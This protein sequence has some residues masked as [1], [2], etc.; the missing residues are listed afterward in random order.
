MADS[1]NVGYASV[2]VIPVVKDIGNNTAT[3]LGVPMAKAGEAAGKAAGAGIVNGLSASKAA[4]EKASAGIAAARR[5]EEDAAGKVRTAE[6]QLQSLRSRGI[7]DVGRLTA[8]EEKVA[9]ARRDEAAASDKTKTATADLERAQ[10]KHADTLNGTA[11]ASKNAASGITQ[12]GD[13]SDATAGRVQAFSLGAVAGAGLALLADKAMEAVKFIGE[14]GETFEVVRS[15][16]QLSTGASGAAL[17]GLTESVKNVAK[18]SPASIGVISERMTQLYQR[19]GLTGESLETLTKQVNKA[20]A[21]LGQ[22]LDIR[23]I[24]QSMA[25]FG[26]QGKDMSGVLDD[27]F[28]VARS[29][30]VGMNELAGSVIRAAPSLQEFGFSLS[31]SVS[32]VGNLDKA[33]VDASSVLQTFGKGLVSIAKAG[34]S[35]KEAFKD[36]TTQIQG[37]IKA[38]DTAGAVNVAGK[39]FGTKGAV[40]FVNAVKSG[41]LNMEQLNGT[42]K[43]AGD[44][45][46]DA[47]GATVTFAKVWGLFKNN[48]IIALEPLATR[49]FEVFIE[50]LSWIKTNGT[51]ALTSLTAVL[52]PVFDAVAPLADRIFPALGTAISGVGTAVTAVTGWMNDHR[53]AM[54]VLGIVVATILTPYLITL[55]VQ[56]TIMGGKAVVA[57]AQNAAAWVMLR[58]E[59]AK[60]AV[61]TVASAWKTVG[62]WI[63]MGAQ[64]VAQGARASAAWVASGARSAGAWIALRLGATGSFL[65]TAASAVA[66]GVRTS[67]AW[68]ASGVKSAAGWAAMKA[69]AVGSFIA[70]AAGAVA[71]AGRTAAVWVASNARIAITTGIA[72]AAFIAQRAAQIA[73][74]IATGALTAA[75]WALNAAMSANPIGLIIAVVVAL[76]AAIVLA[77]KNSETFRNVIQAAWNGIKVVIAAVWG[78]LSTTVFPLFQAAIQ[79]VGSVVMWLWNNVMQPAWNGIRTVIGLWW[80]GVQVYFQFWRSAIS[81]AGDVVMW[82]WN[83]VISPA[84]NGIGSVISGIWSGVISPIF[85]G[86]K[87][88]IQAVGDIVNWLWNNVMI[89]AWD[90]IKNAISAVWNFIRPILD[91]IGKGIHAV[92]E[93]AS[94]VG[95][96][97]RNAFDGVVDVLKSPIH[98]VGKLLASLPGSVMGIDIPGVSTIK[99]WGE[100]LQALRTG[101]TV[102]NGMAGRTRNGVLWGPGSGTSDSILGVDANGIPTA[103]VSNQEGVVTAKAMANGG[104]ALVAW[105]NKTGGLPAFATGGQ[106]GEPYGLPTGSNISYGAPGFPDWVTK[107]GAEHNVKPSTYAG[108]QESDR[109]E[110]GYAPNPQHLNRG[111]DWNGSVE[112]MDAFARWLIGIAPDSPPLEQI[113]WQN[114]NTG[115]KVGWHGRSP[116]AGFSYFAADYGGH[117]DHVHTRQ[118]AAFG[119]SKPP[120]P[121]TTTTVPGYVP[122]ADL[123]PDGTDP[124]LQGGTVTSPGSTTEQPKKT[125]LKSFKELGMEAGGLVAEGIADFFGLPEWMT[126]P[127]GYIDSNSDDGSNVRTSDDKGTTGNAG[128]PNTAPKE[129]DPTKLREAEDKV[130]DKAEAA[131]L[132]QLK[133]DEINKDPKAS[134]S[135]KEAA[136]VAKDKAQ[137]EAEQAKEDLEKLKKQDAEAKAA[138]AAGTTSGDVAPGTTGGFVPDKPGGYPSAPTGTGLKGPDLY[139]FQIAKAAKDLGMGLRGATI[140]EAT[141]LVESGDPMKMYANNSDPATLKFPHD[142]ISSDGSS[143]GLFQ[144][145]NNG[146]WGTAADRMDPYRSAKMFFNGLKGV[147]GW[148]TMDMGAAAQAVQ[149]SAFPDK[150]AGKMGRGGELAKASKLF[151]T[152]GVWEPDTWGYNGLKEPELVIK[153]NQWGVMDRNAAVV[154]RLANT[155]RG[156]DGGKLADTVNI[157]GYT[158]AEISAEWRKYQWSRTA[159]YGSSRNR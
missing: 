4:V 143:S 116:D 55:G 132:A 128:T 149:R 146:A 119:S 67:A 51:N 144:Q 77:Y 133:L 82:L 83:N 93:I 136:K 152:G 58:V 159:G 117:T 108:H 65:A 19:T 44:S 48:V 35:P 111:I 80:T 121:E 115:A 15:K 98:A 3:Q 94:K 68:V 22:D 1:A 71:N 10:K 134:A 141:A 73:G 89:P 29:T 107:L 122:P 145:Q 66:Q 150:Y 88:A 5:K 28:R 53:T 84:F 60:S 151:D 155:G 92:G 50:G 130:T 62:G 72:T 47:E 76:V 100:T 38:G 104:A 114:P 39:I 69:A 18:G 54:A 124:N 120:V 106:V 41:Q 30:G 20:G 7:T 97:M 17:E 59:A 154:E 95:D 123:N 102:N 138:K 46:L 147:A 156:S 57:G 157:Q 52:T 139:A 21:A 13:A 125:R 49:F 75:Q 70:T 140:G 126:D 45:I 148:E 31:D 118:S 40:Q 34:Q 112:A 91:N 96:A 23:T 109:N 24:S 158:A 25:A 153:R 61:I 64:A 90:G 103:L 113:I 8:A 74:T 56:W 2:Q 101:G 37:F 9:K 32:L 81:L 42:T 11:S 135:R 6:A 43:I 110:A 85:N 105:L 86:F 129:V 33:G 27:M 131:R 142:A 12:V 78:W 14:I 63:L 36:V 79:A 16:I 87:A 137:R 127:Q 26:V 99:S